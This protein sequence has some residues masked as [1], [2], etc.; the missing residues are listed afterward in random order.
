MIMISE[1]ENHGIVV[2]FAEKFEGIKVNSEKINQLVKAVCK[3]FELQQATISI[4]V[5]DD[6]EIIKV[7]KEF[8]DHNYVTDVI[9]FDL[10]DDQTPFY[11]TFELIVN[12]QMALRQAEERGHNSQAELALYITHGLL[13][14]LGYDDADPDD[15][16]LM[17][18]MEDKILNSLG[19]G[20]VYG[21]Q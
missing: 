9:S 7:N 13:H 12:G 16:K 6:Q 19:F 14:N 3:R 10:S 8:L 20:T 5:V 18:D 2:Q 21:T 4:A 11:A 17:H 1:K 15:A